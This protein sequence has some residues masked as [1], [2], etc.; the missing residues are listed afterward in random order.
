[1]NR[2]VDLAAEELRGE[3]KANMVTMRGIAKREEIPTFEERFKLSAAA[4]AGYPM[5]RGVAGLV[6]MTVLPV[7][8]TPDLLVD[9]LGEHYAQFD[10][11][12]LHY[13]RTDSTGEDGDFDRKVGATEEF[14]TIV[15]E[16]RDLD[17]DVL[18]VTGDHSTPSALASH[19]WH[20]VPVVLAAKSAR[21]DAVS[22]FGESHC[23]AG[24]LGMMRAIDLMP[25]MMAHAGRLAKFGA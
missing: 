18:L 15:P 1:L 16:V 24:G 7:A 10:F 22:A 9:S 23:L 21:R 4:I 25:L 11:F 3:P 8:G 6:G 17:P 12:F 14:D 13:K 5:Y 19:S 20:P 2:F